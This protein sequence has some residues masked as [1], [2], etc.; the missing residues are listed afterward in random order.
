[1]ATAIDEQNTGVHTHLP[2]Q[3]P[4]QPLLPAALPLILA[5]E[6]TLD[7]SYERSGVLMVVA[8]CVRLSGQ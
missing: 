1:M 2:Y 5:I 8:S 3:F 7:T 4:L 6:S